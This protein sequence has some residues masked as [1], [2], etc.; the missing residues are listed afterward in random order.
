MGGQEDFVASLEA[1][2]AGRREALREP[3]TPEELLA[4]RDGRLDEA[5]RR[6]IEAKIDVYPDAARALADLSAFPEVEPAPGAPAISEA[7]VAGRWQGF[8]QRL[9]EGGERS[10]APYGGE[11][12]WATAAGATPRR[13]SLAPLAVAAAVALA[14]GSVGGFFVG[15]ALRDAQPK[16]D[17]NVTIAELAPLDEDRS[18]SG[19]TATV[20]LAA[21]SEALVLILGLTEP[22]G[23]GEFSDYQVEI[24]DSEGSTVWSREGL[25]PS[26]L[27]DF[28]LSLRRGAL[29]PG[30][31]RIQLFGATELA[32]TQLAAY[33]LRLI[34]GP[35]AP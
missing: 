4:Y 2:M 21:S 26:P 20:E 7:E 18:R 1:I 15:R 14:V 3:P 34:L 30:A 8:R 19:D 12:E 23:E 9:G 11:P 29:K 13:R 31:Y 17:I 27:G 6:A 22:P 33:E 5:E 16:A 28:H 10:Q 24:V 32:R 35:E 25:R